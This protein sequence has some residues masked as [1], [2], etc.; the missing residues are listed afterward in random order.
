MS[1]RHLS[2]SSIA[3]F[4]LYYP[5]HVIQSAGAFE[6][7]RVLNTEKNQ[8][9]GGS[10]SG[11]ARKE[12]L[13]ASKVIVQSQKQQA[14]KQGTNP[15]A[16]EV[17]V[18]SLK[19]GEQVLSSSTNAAADNQGVVLQEP[20][21]DE[22]VESALLQAGELSQEPYG[23]ST[24]T[25]SR[26]SLARGA[27]TRQ[28]GAVLQPQPALLTSNKNRI[29]LSKNYTMYV[30]EDEKL[31]DNAELTSRASE[32]FV[33][34]LRTSVIQEQDKQRLYNSEVEQRG[35]K[36]RYHDSSARTS[37][38]TRRE[39][40][41][42]NDL[43]YHDPAMAI[44][45]AILPPASSSTGNGAPTSSEDERR[46]HSREIGEE[47]IIDT[48]TEVGEDEEDLEA[49]AATP[50]SAFLF[51]QELSQMSTTTTR[52]KHQK[53]S[54]STQTKGQGTA[55]T[56][57][58]VSLILCLIGGA[59]LVI[60]TFVCCLSAPDPSQELLEKRL[61][62][63]NTNLD[64]AVNAERKRKQDIL[65]AATVDVTEE[66]QLDRLEMEQKMEE[67]KMKL[68]EK[69]K[70]AV[71][72]GHKDDFSIQDDE[73]FLTLPPEEQEKLNTA[74]KFAK[75]GIKEDVDGIY[76]NTSGKS[77]LAG[78]SASEPDDDKSHITGTTTEEDMTPVGSEKSGTTSKESSFNS[79]ISEADYEQFEI[80]KV[81]QLKKASTR[82]GLGLGL[83]SDTDGNITPAELSSLSDGD[84]TPHG[85]IKKHHLLSAAAKRKIRAMGRLEVGKSRAKERRQLQLQARGMAVFSSDDDD[86]ET[87]LHHHDHD[88]DEDAVNIMHM[89]V[90][91]GSRKVSEALAQ[92]NLSMSSNKSK[93]SSN[94]ATAGIVTASGGTGTR[95]TAK[96]MAKSSFRSNASKKSSAAGTSNKDEMHKTKS[97]A[98]L[99][100]S[101][102]KS[103]ARDEIP[104]GAG[105]VASDQEVE[106]D[107]SDRE[108]KEDLADWMA[109]DF[110]VGKAYAKRL[111]EQIY[112][113]KAINNSFQQNSSKA[114]QPVPGVVG[115]DVGVEGTTS[116]GV[117]VSQS[118]VVPPALP[119][120]TSP[121]RQ[122]A[123]QNIGMSVNALANHRA[124]QQQEHEN[125]EHI[126]MP[127]LKKDT[128][129]MKEH[130]LDPKNL[131]VGELREKVAEKRMKELNVQTREDEKNKPGFFKSFF[132]KT[133]DVFSSKR[134]NKLDPEGTTANKL[135]GMK[136]ERK[137]KKKQFG[138]EPGN[139]D[140]TI[141][142]IPEQ[143]YA[144][145]ILTVTGKIPKLYAKRL[146]KQ[147][148]DPNNGNEQLISKPN[149]VV[150]NNKKEMKTTSSSAVGKNNKDYRPSQITTT[151]VI[152]KKTGKELTKLVD[153]KAN[154]K[155]YNS[156]KKIGFD[157]EKDGDSLT[158]GV[159]R[160]WINAAE[161]EQDVNHSIDNQH[162]TSPLSRNNHSFLGHLLRS[163]AAAKTDGL[164][165]VEIHIH[166]NLSNAS[167][168]K[169]GASVLDSFK[170]MN[171]T[172]KQQSPSSS[173]NMLKGAA[174]PLKGQKTAENLGAGALVSAPAAQGDALNVTS[175]PGTI[176]DQSPLADAVASS[177]FRRAGAKSAGDKDPNSNNY[178]PAGASELEKTYGV[179]QMEV[180]LTTAGFT[181][182]SAKK[183]TEK[184]IDSSI[185][186]DTNLLATADTESNKIERV[187]TAKK[188]EFEQLLSSA[189]G[190]ITGTAS[191]AEDEPDKEKPVV[192]ETV[193]QEIRKSSLARLQFQKSAITI[194]DVRDKLFTEIKLKNQEDTLLANIPVDY[195][196]A[197]ISLVSAGFE[198]SIA[199]RLAVQVAD[200][201]VYAEELLFTHEKKE[202]QVVGEQQN[203]P[204]VPD[205]EGVVVS[206]P[207]PPKLEQPSSSSP[208]ADLL[209][210]H[211]TDGKRIL[212][213]M[214]L[215]LENETVGR[216]RKYLNQLIEEKKVE[217]AAEDVLRMQ[218]EK[219]AVAMGIL[220]ATAVSQ[221]QLQHPPPEVTG[222][223]TPAGTAETQ[224]L[225]GV[226]TSTTAATTPGTAA[227]ATASA[228]TFGSPHQPITGKEAYRA[229]VA[230][231]F[232]KKGATMLAK[233]LLRKA[234]LDLQPDEFELALRDGLK[235][236]AK[237]MKELRKLNTK[238]M[239]LGFSSGGSSSTTN[240]S[241]GA[242]NSS[243]FKNA[244]L[245]RTSDGGPDTAGA[246]LAGTG[247]PATEG[248]DVPTTTETAAATP[249]QAAGEG[250]AQQRFSEA[251]IHSISST[252]SVERQTRQTQS[253]FGVQRKTPDSAS[254]SR[255]KLQLSGI[256]EQGS[257]APAHAPFAPEGEALEQEGNGGP[258]LLEQSGEQIITADAEG[259]QVVNNALSQQDPSL[260]SFGDPNEAGAGART[261][262]TNQ[263][264]ASKIIIS[265]TT[266]TAVQQTNPDEEVYTE[267]DFQRDLALLKAFQGYG[268]AQTSEAI[269]LD[270]I[271]RR[272]QTEQKVEI[273]LY[274]LRKQKLFQIDSTSSGMK[275]NKKSSYTFAQA[276]AEKKLIETLGLT[277]E[278]A[279]WVVKEVALYTNLEK[280][281][282]TTAKE[283]VADAASTTTPAVGGAAP[284]ADSGSSP[285][286]TA[287]A[288][289][290]LST[291]QGSKEQQPKGGS[292]HG[293]SARHHAAFM[294]SHEQTGSGN[295][296]ATTSTTSAIG[297]A[298]TGGAADGTSNTNPSTATSDDDD[299]DIGY[300][301]SE[302]DDKQE[303][304]FVE[305][306]IHILN[307]HAS[308]THKDHE[309][310]EDIYDHCVPLGHEIHTWDEFQSL[311]ETAIAKEE[312]RKAVEAEAVATFTSSMYGRSFETIAKNQERQKIRKERETRKNKPDCCYSCLFCLCC[313]RRNRKEETIGP[314][315]LGRRSKKKVE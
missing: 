256:S 208:A 18:D 237:E 11:T 181:K 166:A 190:M 162:G 123:A 57:C 312:A 24:T 222:T 211:I 309:K 31:L 108:A 84:K 221:Q 177:L 88:H 205:V 216:L 63:V 196:T 184:L 311:L 131:T 34:E 116:L 283:N 121:T 54:T 233:T 171:T 203:V 32:A 293:K 274:K 198:R 259:E 5:A 144:E 155:A 22:D 153:L 269:S 295:V 137:K 281:T 215:G 217:K 282:T 46:D 284:D 185:P 197:E 120:S 260:V 189:F 287:A 89:S 141:I 98:S 128:E 7:L 60:L 231:G 109:K 93:E 214:G 6:F 76:S 25:S 290:V 69:E 134:K 272:K 227:A 65:N 118:F 40:K 187:S 16:T 271:V 230:T 37:G 41:S 193:Q 51:L 257:T 244:M 172:M 239:G 33:D 250:S 29:S 289:E 246:T 150:K 278:F 210:A 59:G 58:F 101:S 175:Y 270:A 305:F 77:S 291:R 178:R 242:T 238:Q 132:G 286:G 248:A 75:L 173:K 245:G 97:S 100:N 138:V 130:G 160:N 192:D 273:N 146:A 127:K 3:L 277:P 292:S 81:Q 276:R 249:Q 152:S 53:L 229:L 96:S 20:N 30:E 142:S 288:A 314:K 201:T 213:K 232:S 125:A 301:D 82:S 145:S 297:A 105:F 47:D 102:N 202:V 126:V 194:Q 115:G 157:L 14:G 106:S 8:A 148:A 91:A 168:L 70:L 220:P 156:M 83:I 267:E 212:Q 119:S 104:P 74:I 28:A 15:G 124:T 218:Q 285:P 44:Y 294:V 169:P 167:T 279:A 111:A 158:I 107:L 280:E 35:S 136:K 42:T 200:P 251:S 114:H 163:S 176:I 143:R 154:K 315:T 207:P 27:A 253:K 92:A 303:N 129:H 19:E 17:A 140:Y 71:L 87:H 300:S 43:L 262:N 113:K 275:K 188:S 26:I 199:R 307:E 50:T 13:L 179:Y 68:M 261:A 236:K 204:V 147:V 55:D 235:Q 306:D 151:T 266:G 48:T 186:P 4:V 313:F 209:A 183:L 95:A 80:K 38:S 67:I 298:A 304:K 234:G 195:E 99:G 61:A 10:L 103:A 264:N 191:A 112:T 85:S 263:M 225:I 299:D 73:E 78:A 224:P 39:F 66:G 310:L 94:D 52:V 164:A 135:A 72:A 258:L 254:L 122:S 45:D 133:L 228:T 149:Y 265:A 79:E 161:A 255:K 9:K 308:C 247:A 62:E 1:R 139:A 165:N 243:S 302:E 240:M 180:A 252:E 36:R 117:A 174:L 241:L 2:L 226:G 110:R 268:N 49:P 21:N 23:I 296:A 56:L 90:T 64:N 182:A 86:H 12:K 223:T 170:N 219:N 206:P 159:L